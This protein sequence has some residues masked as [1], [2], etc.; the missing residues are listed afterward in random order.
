MIRNSCEFFGFVEF[1]VEE[2]I[3]IF[4]SCSSNLNV[5]KSDSDCGENHIGNVPRSIM[6]KGTS[7]R[8]KNLLPG[9]LYGNF[10]PGD[11][12]KLMITYRRDRSHDYTMQGACGVVYQG[13][14]HFFGGRRPFQWQHFKI[15]KRR[16]E[17]L[18]KMTKLKDL[19]YFLTGHCCRGHMFITLQ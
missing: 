4:H 19:K 15:E 18:V 17:K 12:D 9:Y 14:M 16:S 2:S 1:P 5:N 8:R 3:L 10:D 13:D 11:Q 6:T 7:T